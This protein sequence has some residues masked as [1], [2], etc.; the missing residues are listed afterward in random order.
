MKKAVY[1]GE[2]LQLNKLLDCQQRESFTAGRP[3]HDEMLFIIIHQAYELWFKQILFELDAVMDIFRKTDVTESAIAQAVAHLNRV[4]EIQKLLI[5]QIDVLETMTPLD[6]LDFR[7]FLVPASGFQSWQFRLIETT[8][9]LKHDNRVT[10]GNMSY[11]ERLQGDDRARLEQA[12]TQPSLFDLLEKWLERTPFLSFRDFKFWEMYQ[13][14]VTDMLDGDSDLIAGNPTLTAEERAKQQEMLS[15]TRAEFAVLFDEEA[16]AA[17][18]KEGA[19]RLSHKALQAALL[20]QLYRDQ[21]ILHM[22]YQLL[23]LL[24]DIDENF[25]TWRYRHSLMVLRMIGSK[26]G[27][28]GSSGHDYLRQTARTH[29]VFGDLF[30]MSTFF[31]PRSA[32]PSLPTD[33]QES[34]N[35]HYSAQKSA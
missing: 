4:E 20:I 12:E 23:S 19:W 1:Y 22:P 7:D 5:H 13:R 14:A 35:F 28:G 8:L 24:M 29:K 11:L 15:K 9:G 17:L 2:Y 31:I 3:A 10:F 33:I 18:Q 32:L 16:H 6:F 25:T 34:L 26:I 30:A 21:P 27:T